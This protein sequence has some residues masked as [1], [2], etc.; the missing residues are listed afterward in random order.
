MRF[1]AKC[2]RD[3]RSV[4][5][6][7]HL[8]VDCYLELMGR[9]LFPM[10]VDL[11]H[12]PSC[13]SYRVGGEWISP[14]DVGNDE[15]VIIAYILE[16]ALKMPEGVDEADVE[17]LRVVGTDYG[18]F[19]E[20]V[21]RISVGGSQYK[22]KRRTGLR[23]ERRLCPACYKIRGKGYE[24]VIQVRGLPSLSDDLLESIEERLKRLPEP[25]RASIAEVKLLR[26]GIDLKLI[27]RHAAQS[28]TNII[29][30]EFGGRVMETEENTAGRGSRA[31]KR[32]RL[33][34]SLRIPSIEEGSYIR[35]N[36]Q[37]YIVEK[38]SEENVTLINRDGKRVTMTKKDL[39]KSWV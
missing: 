18:E 36:G 15:R 22:I 28:I 37:P 33:V 1:C 19:V 5:I 38:V 20:A 34:I 32:S 23:R 31:G 2:G 10:S 29:R 26:E 27:S 39:V 35:I 21:V 7:R 30:K 25:L 4:P 12:C 14:E 8:C 16:S 3:E 6:L 17:D 13:G 24:A 9:D 11:T